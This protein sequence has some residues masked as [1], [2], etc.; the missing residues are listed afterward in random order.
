MKALKKLCLLVL[1]PGLS[2]AM[3]GCASNEELF[4][5]Y[6]AYCQGS[7]CVA[8][9]VEVIYEKVTVAA[10]TYPWEPA[11]YFGYDLSEI[12][13]SESVRLDRNI[14]I[15]KTYSDFKISLQAF[16]DSVASFAYNARLAERRRLA[17]I[18]YLLANGI[19][20]DRIVSSSGSES[21]PVLPS[22]S[23][24]DRI[25]NRRVEM[26]LLDNNGRPVSYGIALPEEP[27]QF[28]PPF[29]AEKIIE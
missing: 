15:L 22:D 18:D 7:S 11:I 20:E 27:E 17:V 2:A 26:M 19:S 12:D 3:I 1:L 10:E 24:G 21:L 25:I 16:T 23:V 13:S 4:A 14:E 9:Q 29:P 5:E 28:T 8:T 6:D